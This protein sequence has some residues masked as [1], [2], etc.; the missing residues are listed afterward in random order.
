M[1][2]I[3]KY[4][5]MADVREAPMRIGTEEPWALYNY[6]TRGPWGEGGW[7]RFGGTPYLVTFLL[8]LSVPWFVTGAG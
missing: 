6:G 3:S 4:G 1:D 5:F 8:V 7:S 2:G